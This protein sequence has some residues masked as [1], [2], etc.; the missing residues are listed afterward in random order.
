MK[1]HVSTNFNVPLSRDIDAVSF[2]AF[3]VTNKYAFLSG[4]LW[5]SPLFF[6]HMNIHRSAKN[7]HVVD[8]RFLASKDMRFHEEVVFRQTQELSKE[9]EEPPSEIPNLE[10][11]REEEES[12]P[13]IPD[14]P[15]ELECS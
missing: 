1:Y 15:E 14:V 8:C 13:Q 9:D 4:S 11:Q 6:W 7:P 2:Q 12:E 5:L 3:T 10:V